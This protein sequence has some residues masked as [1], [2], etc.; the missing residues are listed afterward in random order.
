[1]A[2]EH[3]GSLSFDTEL[4]N[5]GFEKG[6]Q[7]MLDAIDSLTKQVEKM[8]STMEKSFDQMIKTFKN[9]ADASYAQADAMSAATEKAEAAAA[10]Q[11]K[12]SRNAN[13]AARSVNRESAEIRNL[14][15]E[16]ERLDKQIAKEEK[17]LDSYYQ[18]INAAHELGEEARKLATTEAERQRARETEA[19]QHE[20]INSKYEEQL[21]DL[22]Q[23]EDQ[24]KALVNQVKKIKEAEKAA[25]EQAEA[26]KAAQKAQTEQAKKAAEE[27]QK[28]ATET[29]QATKTET[30]EVKKLREEYERIYARM[31]E[32]AED[33]SL[34]LR[35]NTKS[36]RTE[37]PEGIAKRKEY[38]ELQKELVSV[39]VRLAALEKAGAEQAAQTAATEAQAAEQA[40]Q[41]AQTQ[42]AA[43]REKTEAQAEAAEQ[44][45]Q[46][47]ASEQAAAET[48]HAGQ[49]QAKQ[50][51][52]EV[53]EKLKEQEEVHTSVFSRMA[54]NLQ[55]YA[56][57]ARKVAITNNNLVKKLT[58]LKTM[59]LARVKRMFISAIFKDMQ[60][61]L[62]GLRK[63]Y[64]A[65]D[66]AM[67]RMKAATQRA[68]GTIAIA[69][70]H[71]VVTAEPYITRL[72]NLLTKGIE[73][74][75]KFIS[76]LTGVKNI[77]V[78]EV[79]AYSDAVNEAADAQEK[80]NADLYGF[81][82]LNRQS[83]NIGKSE[84]KTKGGTT[85]TEEPAGTSELLE[86]IKKNLP[87]IAKLAAG[88]GAALATWGIGN[89]ILKLLGQNGAEAKLRLAGLAL[90][91]GGA[92]TYALNFAD[93]WK[94]GVSN[95]NI[96]G[97]LGSAA[98]AAAGLGI[99]FKSL[100]AAGVGLAVGGFGMIV[101]G[102]K[103]WIK[104]GELTAE[105]FKS[106]ELGIAGMGAGIAMI[107]GSWIPLL[108]AGVA[109]GGLAIYKNW[110]EIKA[111]LSKGWQELKEDFKRPFS[112]M[113]TVSDDFKMRWQTF[114][115]SVKETWNGIKESFRTGGQ[116]LTAD[117]ERT[118]EKVTTIYQALATSLQEE[119]IRIREVFQT[120]WAELQ[121]DFANIG[122]A[123]QTFW[124]W[125]VTGIT[126]FIGEIQILITNGWIMLQEIWN[127]IILGLQE[128]W[129]MITTGIQTFIME[130]QLLWQELLLFIQTIWTSISTFFTTVWE[131]MKT[132]ATTAAQTIKTFVISA[133]TEVQATTTAVFSAVKSFIQSAFTTIKTAMTT[134]VQSAKTA[135]VAQWNALLASCKAIFQAVHTT[136]V[137]LIQQAASFLAGQSWYGYGVQLMQGFW[138]GLRS[139]MASI[140][141]SVCDFVRRCADAVRSA[142]RIGS[143]SKVFEEIG[144]Y[145]G[146][147]FIVGLE[148]QQ[149]A[150]VKTSEN[151]ANAVTEGLSDN[152]GVDLT[153]NGMQ[154]VIE[155]L[156]TVAEIFRTIAQTMTSMGGLTQPQVSAG[157]VVP[158]KTRVNSG[159]DAEDAHGVVATGLSDILAQLQRLVRN[160]EDGFS[161]TFVIPVSIDG[162]DVF[163]VVVDQNNREIQ[164]T[165]ES[166]IRV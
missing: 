111:K 152:V 158:Y 49:E 149:N 8:G 142:L 83:E 66:S 134:A 51:I 123:L 26:E 87:E 41:A 159:A 44:A 59:L 88:V 117:W 104:T 100:K 72:I 48:L 109:A 39:R 130:C 154:Q 156:S 78:D 47:A 12:T 60:E 96:N 146:E 165:G 106:I 63:Y 74:I 148:D 34:G 22:E 105:S 55:K 112:E 90:A 131:V 50:D 82:Q 116:E 38:L 139:L 35:P 33:G 68:G 127:V 101:A 86:K 16:I 2:A 145:T 11:E 120:G 114:S 37:S 161:G 9:V 52:E 143:P 61:Q 65:Y 25:A 58:S 46:T 28:A 32:L 113:V 36:K 163:E 122:V 135:V 137:T 89:T 108:V 126:E 45:N 1:M 99:A 129:L 95:A 6:S 125:I 13:R 40:T 124:Q 30:E 128:V 21:R 4:D 29:T 162:R 70:A 24:R 27:K 121:A 53:K 14:Q 85:W 119:G 79:S 31:D 80:L 20:F 141:Q 15:K 147:G 110:D 140:W 64:T 54:Q 164:R 98:V 10:S 166:P 57:N 84:E 103:D 81:D 118:K 94:N 93:A 18:E 132:A 7:K 75:N 97:M 71:L 144:K 160:T 153:A 91:I 150:A 133:W 62:Q 69:I 43:T 76:L 136:V 73:K 67:T 107:T 42:T 92:T 115:A 77:K 157:S 3:D 151:L 17:G 102:A 19:L 155:K 23:L 5:K 56:S 138:N